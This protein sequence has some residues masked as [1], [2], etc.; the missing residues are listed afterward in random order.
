M[1]HLDLVINNICYFYL[2]R[3]IFILDRKTYVRSPKN[4]RFKLSEI[5][6]F[7]SVLVAGGA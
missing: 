5:K 3:K 4:G 2:E 6:D 1:F 7:S